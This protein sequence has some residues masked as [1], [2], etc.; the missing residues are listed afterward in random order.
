MELTAVQSILRKRAADP[1]AV[2]DQAGKGGVG[3][4]STQVPA[5]MPQAP[6]PALLAAFGAWLSQNGVDPSQATPEQLQALF[7][8]FSSYV[9]QLQS[10]GM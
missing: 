6:N 10:Q 1:N 3:A 9:A 7:Q 8:G 4:P 2:Q 5:A